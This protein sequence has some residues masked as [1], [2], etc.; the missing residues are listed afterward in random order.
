MHLW[1][2]AWNERLACSLVQDGP[3]RCVS[4]VD[5]VYAVSALLY[6]GSRKGPCEGAKDYIEK[7][8]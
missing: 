3:K 5:A 8:Q 2:C 4:A 1:A 6:S 7:F